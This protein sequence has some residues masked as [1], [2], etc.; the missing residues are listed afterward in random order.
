MEIII[1][2]V[3]IAILGISGAILGLTIYG[4]TSRQD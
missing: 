4:I 1:L 2:T 3:V